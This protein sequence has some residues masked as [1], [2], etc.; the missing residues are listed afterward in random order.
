MFDE[1]NYLG[2]VLNSLYSG[3][4]QSS[5][6]DYIPEKI[7]EDL[8]SVNYSDVES[9]D[10]SSFLSKSKAFSEYALVIDDLL[11][12]IDD[13]IVFEDY[14]E[15]EGIALLDES[16]E[17]RE[18]KDM[19]SLISFSDMHSC[20]VDL[21]TNLRDSSVYFSDVIQYSQSE[22][23]TE[24]KIGDSLPFIA[25][26]LGLSSSKSANIDQYSLGNSAVMSS[27][28]F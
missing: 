3:E 15:D 1:I 17:I 2:T 11:E 14:F 24:N 27:W 8:L 19:S 22:A 20:T 25:P 4:S 12:W 9:L 10:N 5:E 28:F 16:L 6:L 26:V 18:D 21:H 23:L 13:S 7:Q